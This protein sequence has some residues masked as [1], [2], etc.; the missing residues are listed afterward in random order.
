[1]SGFQNGYEVL[2]GDNYAYPTDFAYDGRALTV[3]MSAGVDENLRETKIT[4][5]P[6]WFS[7]SDASD[8][9]PV[10]PYYDDPI[11][12]LGLGSLKQ[13]SERDEFE[14]LCYHFDHFDHDFKV[15]C[16]KPPIIEDVTSNNILTNS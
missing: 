13:W 8:K 12:G 7:V 1:M 15:I 10:P 2:L 16:I 6:R 11:K 5:E 9:L 14:I 3:L 4:F